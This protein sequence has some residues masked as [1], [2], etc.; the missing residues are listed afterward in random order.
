M[1]Y[2]LKPIKH[3]LDLVVVSISRAGVALHLQL[4]LYHESLTHKQN[5]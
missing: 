3:S 4:T 1:L 5:N 2:I